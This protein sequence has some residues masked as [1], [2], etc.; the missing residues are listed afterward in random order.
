[1]ESIRHIQ[2]DPLRVAEVM[3]Y[4]FERRKEARERQRR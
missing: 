3:A 1:M 2:P 4:L